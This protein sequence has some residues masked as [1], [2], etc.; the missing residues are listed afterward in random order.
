MRAQAELQGVSNLLSLSLNAAYSFFTTNRTANDITFQLDGMMV[1]I[2]VEPLEASNYGPAQAF[3]S[4]TLAGFYNN[5][6]DFLLQSDVSCAV[7]LVSEATN[8]ATATATA[9][10]IMLQSDISCAVSLVNEATATAIMP[11]HPGM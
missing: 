8:T 2:N 11:G 10:A 9:T 1:V 3:A 5:T 6:F 4:Q 7:S